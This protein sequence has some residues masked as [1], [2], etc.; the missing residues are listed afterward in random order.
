MILN[1]VFCSFVAEEILSEIDNSIL[2]TWCKHKIYSCNK[3][4]K[5]QETQSEYLNIKDSTL[6]PL[7]DVIQDRVNKICGSIGIHEHK[8]TRAWT[9]LNNSPAIDQPHLH[10]RSVLTCVYYVK[11][12]EKSGNLVVQN[13]I[14]VLDYVFGKEITKNYTAFTSAEMEIKPTTGRL[15]IF[16]S[17]LMHY[18]KPNLSNE[19]RISIALE[20]SFFAP[21]AQLVEQRISNAKVGSSNLSRGTNKYE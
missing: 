11:G 21:L 18:V 5:T 2:E 3:F 16:P 13:P 19:E 1:P 14:T 9:N 12:N 10:S 8:I 15:I 20:T 4:I 7:L 17:W 6:K